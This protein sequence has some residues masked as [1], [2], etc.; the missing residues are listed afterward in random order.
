[1]MLRAPRK[2]SGRATTNEKAVAMM[3]RK[4]V[5]IIFHQAVSMYV[6]N[7]SRGVMIEKSHLKSSAIL[8]MTYSGFAR[9]VSMLVIFRPM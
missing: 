4:I 6:S 7:S 2:D 9:P 5:S 8:L 1:M 3:P